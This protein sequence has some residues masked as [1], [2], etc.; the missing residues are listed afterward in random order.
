MAT[1]AV[2]AAEPPHMPPT[3][4][5]SSERYTAGLRFQDLQYTLC[6]VSEEGQRP[7]VTLY[8]GI[9]HGRTS[10]DRRQAAAVDS[11]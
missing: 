6:W 11:P 5:P 2:N 10:G 7:N 8:V 1:G 3:P 4:G 9:E